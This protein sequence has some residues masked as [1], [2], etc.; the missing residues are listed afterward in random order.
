MKNTKYTNTE[1]NSM[2]IWLGK[3]TYDGGGMHPCPPLATPLP[4]HYIAVFYTGLVYNK[5]KSAFNCGGTV[6]HFGSTFL[7]E[8]DS[9]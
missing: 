3:N 4:P 9:L 1:I 8:M 6:S 5:R 2:K 7:L